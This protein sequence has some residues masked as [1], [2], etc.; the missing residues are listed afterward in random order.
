MPSED[1]GKLR[2]SKGTL[3]SELGFSTSGEPRRA[4]ICRWEA[5]LELRRALLGFRLEPVTRCPLETVDRPS[6]RTIRESG[7]WLV[8]RGRGRSLGSGTRGAVRPRPG[9]AR[10]D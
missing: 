1:E 2:Y 7:D 9:V 4:R 10:D 3:R 8:D 5:E 6:G